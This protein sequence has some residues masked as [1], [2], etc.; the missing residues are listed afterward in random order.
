LWFYMKYIEKYF[1]VKILLT[2][3]CKHVEIKK[4]IYEIEKKRDLIWNASLRRSKRRLCIVVIRKHS[5]RKQN[6]LITKSENITKGTRKQRKY[7]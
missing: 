7:I 6:L 3:Y 4:N 5:P 2:Y 1:G